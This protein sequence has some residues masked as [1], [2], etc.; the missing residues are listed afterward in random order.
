MEAVTSREAAAA[1]ERCSA[2][3]GWRIPNFASEDN[4]RRGVLVAAACVSSIE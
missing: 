3:R 4:G 1:A 2:V